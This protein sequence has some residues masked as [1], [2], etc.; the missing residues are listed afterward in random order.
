MAQ[1]A[2]PHAPARTEDRSA[3]L[4]R[5]THQRL[6]DDGKFSLDLNKVPDGYVMQFKRDAL[7]GQN[8]RGNQVEVRRYHWTP[9]PH[10]MQPHFLGHTAKSPD[11]H[12]VV[13]GLGLYMRPEYLNEEAEKER[14]QETAAQT[15]NQLQ[16]LRLQSRGEVGD[17][18][19]RYK[20]N[21]VAAPQEVE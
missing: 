2:S 15:N 13:G 1:A 14:L 8:D 11:E 7:I 10:K 16:A 9:V 3:R 19:T 4:Q 21:K 20:Q 5:P 18:Y 6:T 12:I 17:R